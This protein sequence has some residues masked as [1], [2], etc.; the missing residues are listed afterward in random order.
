MCIALLIEI[1]EQFPLCFCVQH[2]CQRNRSPLWRSGSLQGLFLFRRLL[3]LRLRRLFFVARPKNI[4]FYR[5]ATKSTPSAKRFAYDFYCYIY[6][7]CIS[8]CVST[9]VC[10]HTYMCVQH[11]FMCVSSAFFTWHIFRRFAAVLSAPQQRKC[12]L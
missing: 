9:C 12:Q 1:A 3:R 2:N 11:L 5:V 7:M 6:D 8:I 4:N 10:I